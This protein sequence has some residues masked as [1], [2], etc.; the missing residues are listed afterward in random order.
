MYTYGACPNSPP[1]ARGTNCPNGKKSKMKTL[2][3]KTQ[4][5]WFAKIWRTWK[6]W[7]LR[8]PKSLENFET[9]KLWFAKTPNTFQKSDVQKVLKLRNFETLEFSAQNFGKLK[10]SFSLQNSEFTTTAAA[11]SSS[12]ARL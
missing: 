4:K 5:L 1:P 7:E 8:S 11:A 6:L 9:L 12:C 2:F 3:A 10:N